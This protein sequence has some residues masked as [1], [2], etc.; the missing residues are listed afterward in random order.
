MLRTGSEW[1]DLVVTFIY[2]DDYSN[3]MEKKIL[4]RIPQKSLD[5]AR[6]FLFDNHPKA[7]SRFALRQVVTVQWS[8][9]EDILKYLVVLGDAE[10]IETTGDEV[11]WRYKPRAN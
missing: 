11:F 6:K 5:R 1:L 3:V 2:T 8:S 9:L 10:K 4:G 7:V